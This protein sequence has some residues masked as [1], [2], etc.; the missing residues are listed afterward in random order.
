MHDFLYILIDFITIFIQTLTDQLFRIQVLLH[1]VRIQADVGKRCLNI[2]GKR[3][4]HCLLFL[5]QRCFF[6]LMMAQLLLHHINCPD[7]FAEE[8]M[9]LLG[10][11]I[12]EISVFQS[13]CHSLHIMKG[14]YNLPADIE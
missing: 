10:Q 2:M 9:L 3:G 4:N 8:S 11:L 14:L 5:H 12:R 6:F 1:C 13:C 7:K